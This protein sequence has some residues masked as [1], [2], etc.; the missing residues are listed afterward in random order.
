MILSLFLSPCVSV[1]LS[2]FLTLVL[3]QPLTYRDTGLARGARRGP[4]RQ[5]S[6]LRRAVG[7]LDGRSGRGSGGF[8]ARDRVCWV[9][10]LALGEGV[11]GRLLR[12]SFWQLVLVFFCVCGVGRRLILLIGLVSWEIKGSWKCE[13]DGRILG[14]RVAVSLRFSISED[15]CRLWMGIQSQICFC[16][17]VL[18]RLFVVNLMFAF[19]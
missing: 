3:S 19:A 4:S 2:F 12:L 16:S 17:R 8:R 10:R 18:D 13:S 7:D 11:R 6:R 1:F 5:S 15:K 9:G 14:R